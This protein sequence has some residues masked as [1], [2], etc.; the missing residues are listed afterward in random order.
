MRQR[1]V[2]DKGL[3]A[4]TRER[5]HIADVEPPNPFVEALPLDTLIPIVLDRLK[6][7]THKKLTALATDWP[8]IVGP[9]LAPNTRPGQLENGC[10]TIFVTHPAWIFELR[11]APQHE[12]LARLKT[13]YGA[14]EIKTLR[15]AV[16]PAPPAP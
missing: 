15:F 7:D 10:L 3:W 6:L 5:F 13:R 16:D 12:I 2:Y 8:E 9:Q 1:K 4:I 11:G 14:N